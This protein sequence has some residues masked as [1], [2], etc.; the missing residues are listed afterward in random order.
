MSEHLEQKAR[1]ANQAWS[2]EHLARWRSHKEVFAAR[3]I[4]VDIETGILRVDE[5]G[6]YKASQQMLAAKRPQVGD[7]LVIY[8]DGFASISPDKA[9]VEG[10]TQVE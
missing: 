5:R 1:E 8:D 7:W 2:K 9:F 6:F 3:I 4:E 10:Y